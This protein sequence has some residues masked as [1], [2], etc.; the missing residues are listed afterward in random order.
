MHTS[1]VTCLP[2][3]W[4]CSELPYQ[5]PTKNVGPVQS[6]HYHLLIKWDWL[7]YVI[8]QSLTHSIL[9]RSTIFLLDFRTV[10]GTVLMMWYF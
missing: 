2:E 10:N 4:C 5:N 8:L 3:D 9:S 7:F 1:R 6:G